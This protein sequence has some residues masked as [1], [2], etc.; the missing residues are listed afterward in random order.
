MSSKKK[1]VKKVAKKQP[2]SRRAPVAKKAPARRTVAKHPA[3]VKA[4]L[5]MDP[6]E[7]FVRLVRRI[8]VEESQRL[9]DAVIDTETPRGRL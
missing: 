7:E 2:A 6:R 9:L 8:G 5:P 4:A 1:S 3:K